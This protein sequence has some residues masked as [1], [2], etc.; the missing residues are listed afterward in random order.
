VVAS[1]FVAFALI[2]VGL[3]LSGGW[4]SWTEL[5]GQARSYGWELDP[6]WMGT[7]VV[8]GV[9]ALL[10]TAGLWAALFRASGGRTGAR[11]AAAAWLGSNLGR[12]VPGKIWQLTSI[13]AYARSRG[14]SGATA[15]V[16]SVALQAITLATGAAA[17]V[18]LLGA[19]AFGGASPAALALGAGA[20]LVALQPAVLRGLI[21]LGGRLLKEP[22]EGTDQGLESG[23]L[24]RTGI[25]GLVVW[26]LYGLGFWALLQ[27]L[28]VDNPVTL[29]AATGVFAAGYIAGYVVLLA[30]G[31]MVVREGA[32]AGLLGVVA[33]IPLGPA[34]AIALAARVWTTAAELLAF[35]VASGLGLRRAPDRR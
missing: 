6:V 18:G 4:A 33:G 15:F 25:G 19:R 9:A 34:A 20:I 17:A 29:A 2:A 35:A 1:A 22:A 31:G 5:E 27:G 11:E 13:A 24:L 26:A 30:P 7:A 8:C 21:R 14:D 32:I 10:G 23:G 3:A 12:Y 16:V 28:V